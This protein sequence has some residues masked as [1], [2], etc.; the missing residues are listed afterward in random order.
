VDSTSERLYTSVTDVHEKGKARARML[1]LCSPKRSST[2][3]LDESSA[4]DGSS[5]LS[6]VPSARYVFDHVSC[7]V[8]E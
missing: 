2:A 3:L 1:P 7:T 8:N 4:T 6:S 5:V